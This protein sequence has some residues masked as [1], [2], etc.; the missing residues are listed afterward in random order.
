MGGVVDVSKQHHCLFERQLSL[1]MATALSGQTVI[2]IVPEKYPKSAAIN[3]IVQNAVPEKYRPLI[4]AS[5]D[6]VH[7]A[8]MPGSVRIYPASHITYDRKQKRL[9]D[10]PTAI[11]HFLHPELGE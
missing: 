8:G 11:P 6:I 7:I 2:V 10:Y 5:N 9:L 4:R 1:A 3:Y